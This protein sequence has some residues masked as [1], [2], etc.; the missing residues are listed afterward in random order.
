[1]EVNTSNPVNNQ[2]QGL[3]NTPKSAEVRPEEEKDTSQQAV[4][5]EEDSPD[6]RVNLSEMARQNIAETTYPKENNQYA[7]GDDLDEQ[8]ATELAEQT[9]KQL[10]QTNVAIANQAVQKAVDL[11]S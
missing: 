2:I 5:P 1:M 11:F 10:S 6:Y 9:A 3:T 7:A 8:E 4:S